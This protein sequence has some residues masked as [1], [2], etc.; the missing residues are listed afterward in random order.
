MK[1]KNAGV[2]VALAIILAGAGWFLWPWLFPPPLPE[3]ILEGYG[4]IEGTE[5]TVG[6]RVTGR[7][8]S[9]PVAEGQRVEQG[10]LIALISA[11]EIDARLAQ[12]GARVQAAEKQVRQ[13]SA[14]LTTLEHHAAKARVDYR[15]IQALFKEGAASAQQLDQS[16]NNLEEAEGELRSVGDLLAAARAE[17]AAAGALRD[18]AQ[19]AKTETR[20]VAPIAGT[21]ATKV[22]EQGELVFPGK[23]LVVLVD[24]DR[25]YLRVYVPERDIGK[26]KLGDPARVY[27]DSFPDQPFEAVVTEIAKKSE[28]TPKDVHMP[29]ER[30]TLVYSV[31]LEL[32]NPQG[33]LKPGMPADALI[34]WKPDV[35]WE[36]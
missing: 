27:I 3:G 4:R 13:L 16:E 15:R 25:P 11:E 30:V 35:P 19:A 26:V 34:R 10:A 28:F 31:K 32:K 9:L 21:V 6:S 5:V 8:E 20:I 17:V 2:A 24:L 1:A 12:A 7:I 18:E 14:R 33:M 29:D 22:A 23:T 36:R